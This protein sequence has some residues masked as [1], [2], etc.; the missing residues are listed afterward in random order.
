V[1]QEELSYTAAVA[2]SD[3]T[4]VVAIEE[5]SGAIDGIDAFV[6][7]RSLNVS[8]NPNVKDFGF[9]AKLPNLEKLYLSDLG[10]SAIP[11]E[12][13]KLKGLEV[14]GLN[15]NS[16][17]TLTPLKAL[18]KLKKLHI[19][20]NKLKK[21]PKE[22]LKLKHLSHLDLIGNY[23]LEV[24]DV[25]WELEGLE[26]LTLS[27]ARGDNA[28]GPGVFRLTNLRELMLH[29]YWDESSDI[30]QGLEGVGEL[31]KLEKL[32]I[33]GANL[34]RLP[35]S[36]QKLK[37]LKELTIRDK[38]L[39]DVS[40]LM[41]LPALEKL[42]LSSCDIATIPEGFSTLT[43]LR[44]LN[45]AA[46]DPLTSLPGLRDLPALEQLELC[47]YTKMS[48]LPDNLGTLRALKVLKIWGPKEERCQIGF[49]ETLQDLEELYLVH[50]L[51]ETVP[52]TLTKLKH[53]TL[54]RGDEATDDSYLAKL[55]A[56]EKLEVN[57]P[58]FKLPVLP[59]LRSL[60]VGAITGEA[61]LDALSSMP[62]LREFRL[63][64][65][66]V[67]T[68]LPARI[69]TAK[70]LQKL[71]LEFL[72]N[73]QDLSALHDL[74]ELKEFNASYLDRIKNLPSSFATLKALENVSLKDM[75]ELTDIG[76]LG[77]LPRIKTLTMSSLDELEAFPRSFENLKDLER[78]KLYRM[79]KLKD[80]QVLVG[81][82]S[83]RVFDAQYCKS[84]KRNAIAE[85]ENAIANGG[86]QHAVVDLKMSYARF[87]ESGEY[88]KLEGKEDGT[89]TYGFPLW[90]G[91]PAVLLGTIE[92]FSWI[93]DVRDDEESE[94]A[95]ILNGESDMVPLAIPDWGWEGCENEH[96]DANSEEIFLVDTAN[97]KNPVLIWGH[98]GKPDVI[99]ATFDDFLASLRD[100]SLNGDDDDGDG[101]ENTDEDDGSETYLE[102]VEGT[103]SKFWRIVVDGNEHTVTFGKIG[104]AG[105][106]KTKTFDDAAAAQE[107]A[108]KLI[109]SK[110]KKGYE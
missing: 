102:Y 60:S 105:Q 93:D 53:L 18:P 12:V 22:L 88:K 11:K 28:V 103:S 35:E 58:S 1:S 44:E 101:E 19:A 68:E 10:L 89:R 2:H 69:K 74:A 100:F 40:A 76:V 70:G 72:K 65:S 73:L 20:N 81:L 47:I 34:R 107:D 48:A 52:D 108:D 85:V 32:T 75:D 92:D 97:A 109:K 3:P 7:L 78:V 104:T 38:P 71:T 62:N 61:D 50:F 14:L 15:G 31:E 17:S 94:E 42:D 45:L 13:E 26:M 96:Y 55:P 16:I 5:K 8:G 99:H 39:Q 43:G 84:L 46:N 36:I 79:D 30:L 86:T 21:I 57:Q 110:R 37:S 64:R 29:I 66:D 49:L 82:P 56:L 25:L 33:T 87:M 27:N 80:V 41:D 63:H 4:Q 67:F 77:E 51:F 95:A 6:N 23:T 59:N 9:L 91:P 106:S 24:T 98:D 90:F 83:L 54:F